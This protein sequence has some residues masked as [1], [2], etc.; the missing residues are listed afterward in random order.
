VGERLFAAVVPP[1]EVVAEIRRWIEPRRDDAWRWTDPSGWHVTLAFYADVEAWRYDELVDHLAS[2][3]AR[4]TA[5]PMS[6][7][8]VG[9]FGSVARA[10]VLVAEVEDGRDALG[11]LSRRCHTAATTAGIPVA[12]QTYHPHVT[13]GR[14][15]HPADASRYV[16]AL[17]ELPSTAWQVTEIA[18]VQSHLGQGPHRAPRYERRELLPLTPLQERCRPRAKHDGLGSSPTAPP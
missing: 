8:G 10:T 13:L 15:N 12:R 2:A 11:A 18:L 4:T 5:F 3:A 14:R 16:R 9:C 17:A 7:R 1:D 6:L